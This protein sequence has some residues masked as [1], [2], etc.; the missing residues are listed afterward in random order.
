MSGMPYTQQKDARQQNTSVLLR[1]LWRHA[2]LSKAMLAQRSGLTKATVSSIC[3]DLAALGLIRE[4]GQDRTGL[5]RPGN[6]IE[7]D[8]LARGAI[9]VEIS[10]NYS[11]VVVTDLCGAPLWQRSALIAVGSDQE[12]IL[13][14][15]EALISEAIEQARGRALPL[16]GIGVGVPGLVAPGDGGLVSAPA[17]GWQEMPLKQILA[18]RFS[19]PVVVE[20]K[21]RAAAMAEAFSGSAQDAASF[22]YVSIGTDVRS[23]VEAAVVTDNSL[24]RGVRGRAV[25]AGHMILDPDG[26]LCACG[27]RGCWE[28]LVN[29]DREVWLAQARL[30]TGE[31]SVLQRYTEDGAQALEHRAI[32]QAAVERDALA[33]EVAGSVIMNHAL[34]IINLVRLFDPALVVIGFASAALPP[35]Y[36]ARMQIMTGMAE[37]DIP[38]AVRERLIGRGITPPAIVYAVHGSE[39]CMLGG[40]ALLVDAFLRNP[41]VSGD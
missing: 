30:S 15:T 3:N 6:L 13:G 1:D 18:Q 25:D 37:F 12:V 41:P 33:L 20:N 11:A 7:L 35:P 36:R 26:P 29:V 5:G 16:L 2:P 39:A 10:T 17:L 34:G 8:L 9:G 19:L 21:A 4:V 40:A 24:Y 28:A 38:G 31:A 32:H 27:Q 23:T 22:I 14:Q